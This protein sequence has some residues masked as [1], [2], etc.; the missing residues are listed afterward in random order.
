MATTDESI[1]WAGLVP[2]SPK[3]HGKA[4]DRKL[5]K[6]VLLGNREMVCVGNQQFLLPCFFDLTYINF[7][8]TAS[9]FE[10][11]ILTET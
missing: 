2:A 11:M 6:I 3:A 8:M 9:G 4:E 5:N 7:P 10:K 1:P